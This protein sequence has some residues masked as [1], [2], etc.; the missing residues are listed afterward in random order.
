MRTLLLNSPKNRLVRADVSYFPLNLGILAGSLGANGI[1]VE[2]YNAELEDEACLEVWPLSYN[3]KLDLQTKLEKLE[4][5]SPDCRRVV[6]EIEGVIRDYRPDVLGVTCMSG[7]YLIAKYLTER[8]K[9]IAPDCWIIMGGSHPSALPKESL[10]DSVDFIL[11]G[12]ADNSLVELIRLLERGGATRDRL[13]KIKGICFKDGDEVYLNP[14]R[15]YVDISE[16]PVPSRRSMLFAERIKPNAYAHMTVTRGCPFNCTFCSSHTVHGYKVRYRSVES[17]ISEIKE[18]VCDLGSDFVQFQDS[19]FNVNPDWVEEFCKAVAANK[20]DFKWSIQCHVNALSKREEQLDMMLDA[21]LDHII[22]GC[23]VD[24]E[25]LWRRIRKNIKEANLLDLI[26]TFKKKNAKHTVNIM[27]GFPFDD[28]ENFKKRNEFLLK[29]DPQ[30]VGVFLCQPLPGTELFADW[31]AKKQID[32]S[33][34]N[35]MS[36]SAQS[37]TNNYTDLPDERFQELVREAYGI[38]DGINKRNQA[39][40]EGFFYSHSSSRKQQKGGPTA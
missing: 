5:D 20:L 39:Y 26:D 37:P 31:V 36:L 13:R 2:I 21:G 9:E 22:I 3:K 4:F 7:D 29:L 30:H 14:E 6:E 27:Y 34:V 16:S 35:W 10:V 28:E 17:V 33:K 23:E 25:E 18:L 38:I 40:K 24:R 32:V 8:I 12:Q 15:D 19:I 1:E 11:A